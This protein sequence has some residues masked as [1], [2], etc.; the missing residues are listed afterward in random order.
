MLSIRQTFLGK[1]YSKIFK[2]NIEQPEPVQSNVMIP[3]VAMEP[4]LIV[5]SAT[6]SAT[7]MVTPTDRDFYL[8]NAAVSAS[9]VAADGGGSGTITF[10]DSFG[11]SHQ[12]VAPCMT[13]TVVEL[14]QS[15]SLSIAFP[16]QGVLLQRG[17]NIAFTGG[18][19]L[20]NAVIA[21]YTAGF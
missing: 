10:V 11:I 9:H 8:T 12:V 15:N 7:L 20:G 13:S 1:L 19:S 4:E 17:S 5:K 18:T 21:G 14:G 6:T 16:K 2:N 3:T